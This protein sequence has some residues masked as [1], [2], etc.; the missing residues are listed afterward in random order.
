MSPPDCLAKPNTCDSPRPVP[1]P[2][3]FV[4]KKGSKIFS[5]TEDEMPP[6]VSP[7]EMA[8]NSS[9]APACPRMVGSVSH[10]RTLKSSEPS[11]LMASLAF[12]AILTMAVSNWLTSA[13][14]KH[15]SSCNTTSTLISA[16]VT[17]PS[18]SPISFARSQ[19]SNTLGFRGC[20]RANASNC[21]VSF[22]ARPTVSEMA[23]T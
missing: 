2:T 9:S 20:R 12:S 14:T 6:P 22:A 11:P 3:S 1:L 17:V 21:P 10:L 16:P 23:L 13:N 7:R 5:S 8:T 4:V 18:I 19:A 15:S